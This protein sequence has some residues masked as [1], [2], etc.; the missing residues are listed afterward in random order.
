MEGVETSQTQELVG[1]TSRQRRTLRSALPPPHCKKLSPPSTEGNVGD[2]AND[3]ATE[4]AKDVESPPKKK[5]R[6]LMKGGAV[7]TGFEVVVEGKGKGVTDTM[8]VIPVAKS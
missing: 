7:A 5:Q 2:E 1:A 3:E 4:V 8:V 6:K